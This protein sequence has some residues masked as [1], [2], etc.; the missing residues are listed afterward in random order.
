MVHQVRHVN[1]TGDTGPFPAGQHEYL[2]VA[3][4]LAARIRSGEFGESGRLPTARQLMAHYGVGIHVA[5]HARRE[6]MQ[7]GLR[8]RA[9]REGRSSRRARLDPP[10]AR[11]E[12]RP[13]SP[14]GLTRAAGGQHDSPAVE[15]ER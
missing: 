12:H 14:D 10:A 15:Q 8:T 9:R 11:T 3:G 7:R 13:G 6:L 5:N 2:V 1:V 4:R